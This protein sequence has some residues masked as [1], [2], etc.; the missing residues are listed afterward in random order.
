MFLSSG[1]RV[2]GW[3]CNRSITYS[4]EMVPGLHGL[5]FKL[6]QY[7][8]RSCGSGRLFNAPGKEQERTEIRFVYLNSFSQFPGDCPG[9]GLDVKNAVPYGHHNRDPINRTFSDLRKYGTVTT[10]LY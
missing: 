4:G 5:L 7:N 1:R 10:L 8:A 3:W 2:C 9:L 6:A